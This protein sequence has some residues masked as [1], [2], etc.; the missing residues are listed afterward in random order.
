MP[1]SAK[2]TTQRRVTRRLMM[3]KD[4]VMSGQQKLKERMKL[5]S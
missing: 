2:K 4:S 1:G 3:A 5:S